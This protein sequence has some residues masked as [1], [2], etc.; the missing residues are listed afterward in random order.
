M[1]NSGTVTAPLIGGSPEEIIQTALTTREPDQHVAR[2]DLAWW[3]A[4]QERLEIRAEL[5]ARG[6]L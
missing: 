6:L 2:E 5:T 1:P 3:L 4:L